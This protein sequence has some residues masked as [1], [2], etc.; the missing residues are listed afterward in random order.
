MKVI[1]RETG[2]EKQLT[3]I[4]PRMQ[5]D[6]AADVIGA[7]NGWL[8]FDYDEAKGV[9]TC[10]QLAFDYW[11]NVLRKCEQL[12]ARIQHLCQI[13]GSTAV[14]DAITDVDYNDLLMHIQA[15]HQCLD[16]FEN[17]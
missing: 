17:K 3:L 15:V 16:E 9:H 5:T 4:D 1:I 13:Y 11:K 6:Y 8:C 14:Y 7:W 2:E 10:S 12:E